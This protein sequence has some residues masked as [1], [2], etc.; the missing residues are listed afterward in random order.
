MRNLRLNLIY[1]TFLFS[2]TV[3]GHVAL[4]YF[5]REYIWFVTQAIHLYTYK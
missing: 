2:I 1:L 3:I 5:R 4:T